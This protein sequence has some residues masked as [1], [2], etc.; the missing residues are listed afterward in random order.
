MYSA[1]SSQHTQLLPSQTPATIQFVLPLMSFCTCLLLHMS[2]VT[3][4][5]GNEDVGVGG[6]LFNCHMHHQG[7][8]SL[9]CCPHGTN[10]GPEPRTAVSVPLPVLR[11]HAAVL[12]PF[13]FD[14]SPACTACTVTVASCDKLISALCCCRPCCRRHCCRY[15]RRFCMTPVVSF[16]TFSVYK[17]L[18]G[19]LNLPSVFYA[20]SLLHLPKLYLVYFAVIGFQYLTETFVA[21]QRIDQFLGMPEPPPAVHMC[22]RQ[23][24]SSQSPAAAVAVITAA[25]AVAAPAVL[26]VS[27]AAGGA[28]AP[29]RVANGQQQLGVVAA[30][31][32]GGSSD[33]SSN[34]VVVCDL[35]DG[36][37]ELGGADYD[38]ASNIEEMASQVITRHSFGITLCMYG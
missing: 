22:A 7:Q 15:C 32:D 14:S 25:A 18:Y 36:Y 11:M 5:S 17:A 21:L 6:P 8:R 2:V 20:L 33:G 3:G 37:V 31:A 16:V 24:R 19:Q 23:Q 4:L 9:L 1:D 30:A 34:G 27:K 35:P 10:Q 38:W 13:Q 28:V 29:D 12:L 26:P